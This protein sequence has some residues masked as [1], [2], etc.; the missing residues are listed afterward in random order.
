MTLKIEPTF[1]ASF[2]FGFFGTYMMVNPFVPVALRIALLPFLLVG[3]S[4]TIT[5]DWAR[6]VGVKIFAEGSKWGQLVEGIGGG[7]TT[8]IL[9]LTVL[10]FYF[11]VPVVIPS[12]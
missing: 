1:Q 5:Q 6:Y 12:L 2:V 8:T 3:T 7:T 10:H 4:L 11:G 9:I